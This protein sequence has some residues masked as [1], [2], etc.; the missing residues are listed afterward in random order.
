MNKT[1]KY[2]ISAAV[3]GPKNLLSFHGVV[4]IPKARSKPTTNLTL[5]KP[6]LKSI[7]KIIPVVW[8]K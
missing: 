7:Q 1:L 4:L 5:Q 8:L 3:A 2:G 6:V